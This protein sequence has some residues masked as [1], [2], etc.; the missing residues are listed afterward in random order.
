MAAIPPASEPWQRFHQF[1][2]SASGDRSYQN[3]REI[4]LYDSGCRRQHQP[5]GASAFRHGR[6]Q[7]VPA[8]LLLLGQE[9]VSLPGGLSSRLKSAYVAAQKCLRFGSSQGNELETGR[10]IRRVH[11]GGP[12]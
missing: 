10:A 7:E 4:S 3:T 8:W 5:A 1:N 12:K 11:P 6:G 2:R 9:A